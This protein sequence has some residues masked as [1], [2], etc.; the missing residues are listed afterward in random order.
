MG[1][2]RVGGQ[3]SKRSDGGSPRWDLK[4]RLLG[5]VGEGKT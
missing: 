3:H 5:S 1:M 2:K 4:G